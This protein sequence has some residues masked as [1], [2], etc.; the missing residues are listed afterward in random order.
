MFFC[1]V[2]SIQI[3]TKSKVK[4]QL[5]RKGIKKRRSL[6]LNESK[7]RIAFYIKNT[8]SGVHVPSACQIPVLSGLYC[9]Y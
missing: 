4:F 9:A 2:I 1:E 5:A 6:Y 3:V 7:Q 8:Y